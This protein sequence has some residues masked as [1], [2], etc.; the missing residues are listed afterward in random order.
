MEDEALSVPDAIR[1]VLTDNL[2]GLEIDPRCTQIAAFN[3]AL[4][5]WRMAGG[6]I[7]LPPLNIACSGIA[8]EASEA[9]WVALADRLEGFTGLA[10][11]P[12]SLR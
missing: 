9:E 3:V 2:F 5:A 12:G 6:W 10:G 8:P 11:R 1:A 7:R 4:A